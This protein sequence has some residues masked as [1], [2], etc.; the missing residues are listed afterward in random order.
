MA[1]LKQHILKEGIHF[2][3]ICA[4]GAK[5]QAALIIFEIVDPTSYFITS[6]SVTRRIALAVW[7]V[8]ISIGVSVMGLPTASVPFG[9]LVCSVLLAHFHVP[10]E[11]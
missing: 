5:K 7:R 2:L 8:A 9:I 4:V 1:L 3:R 6:F 10:A 11:F